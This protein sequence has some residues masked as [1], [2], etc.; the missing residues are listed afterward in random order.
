M[1]FSDISLFDLRPVVP[2]VAGA[3]ARRGLAG[4]LSWTVRI[5]CSFLCLAGGLSGVANASSSSRANPFLPDAVFSKGHD[6]NANRYD[7]P[8][9]GFVG[10]GGEG[11]ANPNAEYPEEPWQPPVRPSQQN[12]VNP[13]F[14]GWADEVHDYKPTSSVAPGWRFSGNA[15][16]PVTGLLDDIVSLGDLNNADL[17]ETNPDLKKAPGFLIIK[18]NKPVYDAPGADIVI[19]ENGFISEHETEDGSIIG[20]V[21]AELAYVEVSSDGDNYVR[22][23]SVSRTPERVG[24]MGTIRPENVYNLVGKHI[25]A[26]G[27]SWGTPF[28]LADL[29]GLEGTEPGGLV[30]LNNIRFVKIVDIP[31]RGD[32]VDSLGHPI[33]DA[34]FTFGSGGADIEAIGAISHPHTYADWQRLQNTLRLD[35][36]PA[37][38]ELIG[39]EAEDFDGDGIPNL[40][41]Y[42]LALDPRLP[43]PSDQLDFSYDPEAGEC[44]L[45]FR[46]DVRVADYRLVLERSFGDTFPLQ[47]EPVLTLGPL[48]E[49]LAAPDVLLAESVSLLPQASLGVIRR[50]DVTVATLPYG[51]RGA[52]F[53]RLRAE[54]VQEAANGGE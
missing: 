14:L 22:F 43:E 21:F 25:N 24:A 5:T 4:A 26:Y 32:F 3:G 47:W 40:L 46:R 20:E 31:G 35:T 54:P 34:W 30:D 15:L 45:S 16:G 38:F 19:F 8:V 29:Q 51:A 2:P 11:V 52:E 42:M 28:D 17:N 12:Y 36:N 13:V 37:T 41:E 18:F 23:P 53:Y 33:Y 9:P 39:G 6:D 1:A 49:E 48:G 50:Y 27:R 7:A 10:P 44:F